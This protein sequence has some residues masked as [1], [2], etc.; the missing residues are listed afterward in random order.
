MPQLLVVAIN[1]SPNQDGNVSYLLQQAMDKCAKR[2]ADTEYI[3]W[4]E[5]GEERQHRTDCA[6]LLIP[7]R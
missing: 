5:Q 1:G 2:G 3:Y 6:G 4:P 7:G